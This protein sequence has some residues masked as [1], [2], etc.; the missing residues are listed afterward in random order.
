MPSSIITVHVGQCG[1]QIG[2][3]FW[4]T[5]CE[6][7]GI[8]PDGSLTCEDKQ[9]E[10]RKEMFFYESDLGNRY[11]PRSVLVDLEPRVLNRIMSREPVL[12]NID[13]VFQSP[14]GQGAGNNWANGYNQSDELIET[15]FDIL[16][17]E[18]EN[19][20]YLEGFA[21][22]H[23]ITGGTGSGLGSKIMEQIK[24][25][26]PKTILQTYSVYGGQTDVI[27]APYNSILS[28]EWLMENSDMTVGLDNQAL[29]RLA[30]DTMRIQTPS[31]DH[32]NSMVSRIMTS[33]TAPM[34][35]YSPIYTRMSHL[36]AYLNPFPPM[37]FIQTAYAPFTPLDSKFVTNTSPAKILS[38]IMEPKSLISSATLPNAAKSAIGGENID[39]KRVDHCMLSALAILQT[40]TKNH[41]PDLG[42][43]GI[44]QKAQ[45]NNIIY[46][47]WSSSTLN[48]TSCK[49]SPYVEYNTVFRKIAREFDQLRKRSAFLTEF[50]KAADGVDTVKLMDESREKVAQ[51]MDLYEEATTSGF[52][53]MDI[54]K[55]SGV[56]TDTVSTIGSPIGML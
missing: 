24:D 5:M 14:G 32:M 28:L 41:V 55:F 13:N 1:N 51:L 37:Q 47:P 22:C 43:A 36:A 26:F 45:K 3:A 31:N 7:H 30:T 8:G 4:N 17:R 19:A 39:P 44:C 25:R 49:L 42:I 12:H 18:S 48:V 11:V 21:L 20:D 53:D 15:I 29:Y 46:P 34:R 52:L 23:S 10:D 33:L 27:V 16:N 35:F 40:E 38:R 9:G 56:G 2:D 50:N 54:G 6:E